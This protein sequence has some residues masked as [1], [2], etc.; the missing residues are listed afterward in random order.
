MTKI[1][2]NTDLLKFK[3]GQIVEFERLSPKLRV[4]VEN[5]IK[6]SHL[7]NCVEVIEEIGLTKPEPEKVSPEKKSGKKKT[8]G[9]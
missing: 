1:K 8:I 7:D 6:D 5:R 9:E 4:Y 2:F 3:K